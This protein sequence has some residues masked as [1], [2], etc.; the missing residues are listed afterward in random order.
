M[1]VDVVICI[2][3]ELE[4]MVY[5]IVFVVFDFDY[6]FDKLRVIVID[7]GGDSVVESGFVVFWSRVGNVFYILNYGKVMEKFFGVKVVNFNNVF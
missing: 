4:V 7:D 5:G 3:K 2:C 6:F 1:F